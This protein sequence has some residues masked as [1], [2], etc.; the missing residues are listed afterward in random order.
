MPGFLD[1]YGVARVARYSAFNF[2]AGTTAYTLYTVPSGFMFIPLVVVIHTLSADMASTVFTL[3]A[4]GALTDFRTA[5]TA[6]GA[7]AT[8]KSLV[9]Y[10]NYNATPAAGSGLLTTYDEGAFFQIDLTTA[11]GSACTGTI[12]TFG[13]LYDT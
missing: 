10:P 8:T 13:F 5:L 1:Y 12:D 9:V 2:N 11:A 7:S 4:V 3:G 6:S